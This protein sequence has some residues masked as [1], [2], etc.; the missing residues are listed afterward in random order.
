MLVIIEC[1]DFLGFLKVRKTVSEVIITTAMECDSTLQSCVGSL[2]AGHK[3]KLNLT[4]IRRMA[5]GIVISGECSTTRRLES[6]NGPPQVAIVVLNW[7]GWQDTI[8]C[9]ESLFQTDYPQ[10]DVI[11]VD[12]GSDDDSVAKILD[13]AE[14]RIPIDSRF[15]RYSPIGKPMKVE[16]IAEEEIPYFQLAANSSER[17]FANMRLIVVKTGSNKGFARG[18]NIGIQFALKSLNPDYVLLQNNDTVVERSFLHRILKAATENPDAGLLS[19]FVYLYERPDTIQHGGEKIRVFRRTSKPLWKNLTNED[20]IDTDTVAGPS[21]LVSKE[22]L[23]RVG[24]L[25]E[26]FGFLLADIFYSFK[27]RTKGYRV[28]AVPTSRI[29]H[30]GSKSLS[31]I[32]ARVLKYQMAEGIVFHYYFENRVRSATWMFMNIIIYY[33]AAALKTIIRDK[34]LAGVHEMLSGFLE[35]VSH[36]LCG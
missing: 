17:Q 5:Y 24:L 23:N 22:A 35:G 27:M 2:L 33:P 20:V 15:F 16:E 13:Y 10:C 8:E 1:I 30:K 3:Y 28:L 36:V 34:N 7:N 31:K 12:N 9:L 11:V 32:G 26:R 29:W 4:L 14:G 6:P 21:M 18:N 19:P 25:E